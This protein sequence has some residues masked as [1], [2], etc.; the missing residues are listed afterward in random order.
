MSRRVAAIDLGSNTIR[1]LVAEPDPARGIRPLRGEQV[2]AR[3]GEGLAE[4]GALAPAA[5]ERA[6]AAVRGYR[7][8]ARDLGAARVVVVATAAVRQARNGDELMERLRAEP[9]LAPRVASGEEEARLTLLGAAWG[10][11]PIAGPWCLLDVGGGSTEL[12]AAR[13]AQALETV[14]LALGAV[15]LR[16]RFFRHDPIDPGEYATCAAHVAACLAVEAWPTIAPVGPRRLVGTAG[17]VT[18]LAALDLGL[19]AYDPTRVQGYRLTVG[20]IEPLRRRLAALPAVQ[21]AR[22]PCV[23]PGRADLLVPG[24]AIVLAVLRGLELP[25]LTVSDAGFREGILLETVGWNPSVP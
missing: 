9:G 6:L 10:L 23:E 5:V 4:H 24:A 20:A 8:R 14:S 25:E 19:D 18:T 17:T 13:G 15:T 1:L 11:G 7:D 22:L 12:V 2:I 3:L 16:E 21:R